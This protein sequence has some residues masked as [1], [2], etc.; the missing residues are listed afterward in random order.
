[1]RLWVR[2]LTSLLILLI[3]LSA[4]GFWVQRQRSGP[5]PTRL[6]FPS[7]Y[8][9]GTVGERIPVRVSSRQAGVL[10]V[11]LWADGEP[12]SAATNAA[13]SAAP[14]EITLAWQPAETGPHVLFARLYTA[15]GAVL[16]TAPTTLEVVP[17]GE[18]AYVTATNGRPDVVVAR[19][20]GLSRQTWSPDARD[21]AWAN[22]AI[23]LVV[24]GGGIWAQAGAGSRP[25]LVVDA[26][27]Q[28]ERPAWNG[29]TLAFTSRKGGQ[30]QV[31]LRSA[32]GD[33]SAL[34]FEA[35]AVMDPAWSP[36]GSELVV[37]ATREGNTDLYRLSLRTGEIRRL[38]TH[39]ATDRQPAWS[40]DGRVLLFVSDRD[41][42]PQIYWLA[43]TGDRPPLR[44]TDIPFGAEHP[45][46][47]PDGTWFAYSAQLE[48]Q[49]SSREIVLQRLNDN[50]AVRTTFNEVEDTS[51]A[52]RPTPS[53]SPT[54]P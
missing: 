25:Q 54:K 6:L 16:D 41:G 53:V 37:A 10:R 46:W 44:I 48:A 45:A 40:P 34:P 21:P 4:L 38:T 11:E 8:G 43:L 51:P 19:T 1:M 14:W 7:P 26:D 18:L 17:P 5:E 52:W 9:L 2:W 32:A 13:P 27:F 39:P 36:D 12:V 30:P 50:Y 24:R 31:L 28:A 15:D 3:F 47:S 22:E 42:A 20:D 35:E 33:I 23:L 29:N 49:P